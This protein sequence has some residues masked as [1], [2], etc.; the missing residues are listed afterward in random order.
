[1][2]RSEFN[3]GGT[4]G[5]GGHSSRL[6]ALRAANAEA[7]E[8]EEEARMQAFLRMRGLL[9]DMQQMAREFDNEGDGDANA[10]SDDEEVRMPGGD[11]PF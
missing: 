10:D 1:M 9:D 7:L 4:S 2:C 5:G 3:T 6:A 11:Q 8:R